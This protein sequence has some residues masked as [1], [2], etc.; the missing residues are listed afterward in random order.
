MKHCPKCEQNLLTSFFYRDGR[1]KDGLD[2]VCKGCRKA[3][4]AT[5]F[6]EVY[7][8]SHKEEIIERV[9]LSRWKRRNPIQGAPPEIKEEER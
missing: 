5:Y 7:Y 2:A 1:K 3:Y 8:P 4:R 9:K 6:R